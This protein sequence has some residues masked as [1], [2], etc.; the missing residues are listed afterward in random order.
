MAA[1]APRQH[2]PRSNALRREGVLSP[3]MAISSPTRLTRTLVPSRLIPADTFQSNAIRDTQTADR[4]RQRCKHRSAPFAAPTWLDGHQ[5]A[6][7]S[8]RP[9]RVVACVPTTRPLSPA[10]ELVPWRLPAG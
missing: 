8:T 7:S 10:T 9:S 3:I 4:E 2:L 6:T 5:S 1:N